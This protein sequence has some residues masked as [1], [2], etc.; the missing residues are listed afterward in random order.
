MFWNKPTYQFLPLSRRRWTI[1]GSIIIRPITQGLNQLVYWCSPYHN[2]RCSVFSVDIGYAISLSKLLGW[3]M[4]SSLLGWLLERTRTLLKSPTSAD[5]ALS[6]SHHQEPMV[7][8]LF[9]LSMDIY[10]ILYYSKPYW[11]LNNFTILSPAQFMNL[12]YLSYLLR[13]SLSIVGFPCW[14]RRTC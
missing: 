4:I 3:I 10:P 11:I 2:N 14:L 1:I 5:S 12:M 6:D 9:S 7:R 8:L 13:W